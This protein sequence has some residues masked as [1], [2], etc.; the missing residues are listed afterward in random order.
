MEM[1]RVREYFLKTILI[2]D[3]GNTNITC[4][5]CYDGKITQKWRILSDLGKNA[6]EY[7]LQIEHYITN[8]R[9]DFISI[10]SVVPQISII[11]KKM[12]EEHIHTPHIFVNSSTELGLKF[13]MPDP[14]FIGA[15]LIVNAF[16][17]KEKYKANCIIIDLG[18]A[19][20]IQ[21]VGGDGVFYG[22]VI[23]PGVHTSTKSI[24]EKAAQLKDFEFN[25]PENTLGLHTTQSLSLGIIR[26]HAFTIDGFVE[27]IKKEYANLK[28]IK[29][30]MTGG[31]AE[32]IFK[33]TKN[34]DVF[35]EDLQIEG[36][37]MI[38]ENYCDSLP[39]Q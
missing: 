21:L 34:V 36:L 9:I 22:T 33:Y 38:G 17:A 19:T 12:I 29:V 31:V 6:Y 39:I 25:V 24:I 27:N 18:T 32:M 13:Q 28:D 23:I 35:D 26:G 1:V 11:I 20:T 15:D 3:I 30:I 16:I 10:S 8:I 5:I 37:G 2:L 4:G 7:Y 14:S